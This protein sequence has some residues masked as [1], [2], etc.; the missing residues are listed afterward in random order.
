M[1]VEDAASLLARGWAV[2]PVPARTKKPVIE[3]WQNLR[4]TRDDLPGYFV[5]GCNVGVLLGA[6][7]GDLVDIDLDAREAVA[8]ADLFL[9]A[10]ATVF[11]RASKPRAHWLYSCAITTEK[12]QDVE[13][14]ADDVTAML[15][16]IRSTGC[17]TIFPPSEHPGGE[18]VEWSDDGEPASVD[19]FEVHR[20]VVL[21]ACAAVIA[22]HWPVLGAR[23]DAALAAAGYLARAGVDEARVVT[24]IA[25]A[26]RVAGDPEWRDRKRAALDTVAAVRA[27]G[28]VTGGPRLAELLAGDGVKVVAR[29]RR[30]LSADEEQLGEAFHLTD[31]GNAQRFA[32]QHG[33]DVR[34]CYAWSCWL[35]WDGRRWARDTGDGIMTRVKATARSIYIEASNAASEDERKRLAAWAVKSESEPA[36]RRMLILAQSEPGIPVTPA[37]LDRDAFLLTTPTGTLDLRIG[38]LRPCRR[39]DL[40]TKLTAASFVA[41]ARHPVFDAFL[42]RVLP[43]DE[44]RRFVQRVAGYC[45]TGST[46]E[47]KLFLVHGPTAGGKSTLLTALRRALGDYAATAAAETFMERKA[48]GGAPRDDLVKL[49]GC[50][51]VVSSEVK[52]GTRLAETLVKTIFGGD[53]MSARGLYEKTVEFTPTFKLIIAAN[54][55]PRARD[56]DDALWRRIVEIPFSESIPE[57]ERDSAVK[58]TLCNPAEAGAA[59]LAWAVEGALAWSAEGLSAPKAVKAATAEYRDAMDPLRDFLADRCLFVDEVSNTDLRAAYE[60]WARENGVRHPIGGNAFAERLEARDCCRVRRHGG[61]R[62]WTGLRLR[63]PIDPEP[64]TAETA[65]T[66]VSE[67]LSCARAHKRSYAGGVSA[68]SAVSHGEAT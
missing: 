19:T 6:P 33:A 67:T 39:E 1:S 13:R 68:V 35:I 21:L 7:S 52:D 20:A 45:L 24:I 61:E 54:H 3:E 64:E 23:H 48:E 22:R 59:V 57:A 26:A 27:G 62:W 53:D 66:A 32:R 42:E 55:R 2:I 9:P 15:V 37:E 5:N 14:G 49:I 63:T 18:R 34:Y 43:D 12:F 8:L 41:D 60:V 65:E 11:G 51:C 28:A 40:C 16:E 47:E 10:T 30:W 25:N 4:L 31:A 44:V 36:L 56:D 46:K 58:A 17:Q 50:R 38:G 29:M